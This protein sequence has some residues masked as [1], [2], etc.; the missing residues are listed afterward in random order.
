[1]IHAVQHLFHPPMRIKSWP[2]GERQ[3]RIVFITKDLSRSDVEAAYE[4]AQQ[5]MQLKAA[6]G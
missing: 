5:F 3:S 6:A 2:Q 1:V 4:K